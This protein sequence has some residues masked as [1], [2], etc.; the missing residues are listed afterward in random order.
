MKII[1]TELEG[2]AGESIV[3]YRAGAGRSGDGEDA[4]IAGEE[5]GRDNRED[6]VAGVFRAGE[7]LQHIALLG[8]KQFGTKCVF[9]HVVRS[10]RE[11][12]G[13][14]ETAKTHCHI[15]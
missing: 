11:P 15:G 4:W 6:F 13:V 9:G 14:V 7:T 12:V 3:D 5:E 1:G 10:D 8:S 2:F